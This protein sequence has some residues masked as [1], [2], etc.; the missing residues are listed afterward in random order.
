MELGTVRAL[1][2]RG[3][4]FWRGRCVV[5]LKPS[6]EMNDRAFKDDALDDIRSYQGRVVATFENEPEN[7]N[8]FLRAFPDALHF[9]LETIHSP[10]AERPSPE[11]IRSE[12]FRLP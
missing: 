1:T 6:F 9:F 8:L 5:H 4:P 2:D 11:L 7:A 12:D 3:F 10:N